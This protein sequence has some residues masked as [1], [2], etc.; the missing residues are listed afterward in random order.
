[1]TESARY[2]DRYRNDKRYGGNIAVLDALEAERKG[3]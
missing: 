3:E 2:F 1:M